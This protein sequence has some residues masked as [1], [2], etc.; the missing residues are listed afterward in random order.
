MCMPEV[1]STLQIVLDGLKVQLLDCTTTRCFSGT[2]MYLSF[3]GTVIW[4]FN[5]RKGTW[6]FNGT[7][8][9]VL[10]TFQRY[11]NTW[12]SAVQIL[13]VSRVGLRIGYLVLQLHAYLYVFQRY[14]IYSVFSCTNYSRCFNGTIILVSGTNTTV[15][16]K[17]RN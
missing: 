5:G 13:C 15:C 12:F 4:F 1:Q 2:D 9:W 8:T 17:E 7:H 14:I 11:N 6:Y 10:Y 3:N 16:F